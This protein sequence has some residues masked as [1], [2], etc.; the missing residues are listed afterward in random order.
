M[1][2]KAI[3][4]VALRVTALFLL[5]G[6]VDDVGRVLVFEPKLLG[7]GESFGGQEESLAIDYSVLTSLIV[8]VLLITILLF[9]PTL[10]LNR[11]SSLPKDDVYPTAENFMM[12]LVA[13]L[14]LYFVASSV[15]GL[16]NI[17]VMPFFGKGFNITAFFIL[18]TIIQLV[19]G[20]WLLLGNRGI[21]NLI[22]KLRSTKV[23]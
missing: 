22:Y 8:K 7:F 6:L 15:V 2:Q 20:L 10:L 11:I 3:L 4:I 18:P 13:L 5:V 23:S 19:V 9:F 16:L 14:G 1:N 17:V 21:V 12:P